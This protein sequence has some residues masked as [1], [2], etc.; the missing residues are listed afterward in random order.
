M[1]NCVPAS[2]RFGTAACILVVS[3]C[4]SWGFG[5][6]IMD[7]GLMEQSSISLLDESPLVGSPLDETLNLDN[8]P[9]RPMN[10]ISTNAKTRIPQEHATEKFGEDLTM[11]SGRLSA[12]FSCGEDSETCPKGAPGCV[13]ISYLIDQSCIRVRVRWE[14]ETTSLVGH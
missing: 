8:A 2:M 3:L 12:C 4:T 7:L 6:E 1:V 11:F 14:L 9:K 10:A 5:D 13:Y